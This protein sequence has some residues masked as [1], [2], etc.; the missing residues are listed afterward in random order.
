ML[1]SVS[2]GV[3]VYPLAELKRTDREGVCHARNA[4]LYLPLAFDRP[5]H[6]QGDERPLPGG[7]LGSAV[8]VAAELDAVR[9]PLGIHDDPR[10]DAG[11]PL[12][13]AWHTM[14]TAAAL[15]LAGATAIWLQ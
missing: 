3:H 8:R 13:S 5:L 14:R 15:S 10:A 6:A 2:L 4:G 9:E 12:R 1:R 11:D 7:L